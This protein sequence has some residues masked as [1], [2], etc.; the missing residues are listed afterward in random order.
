VSVRELEQQIS[1]HLARISISERFK[2][3]A[4]KYLHELHEKESA[5]R[6]DIIQAQ[7]KA[8]QQC[9]GHIDGLVNLKT[10]SG[11][12]DGSLLSDDEYAHRRGKL[13]KEKSALEELLNDAGHQ[14]EHQLK[15]SEQTFEFAC[16]AQK[17]FAKGDPKTKREILATIGSNLIL[18]DKTLMIEAKKPFFILGNTLSPEKPILQPIEPEKT[19]VAQGR[20]V[21]SI[22]MR[23][24]VRGDLDDVRAFGYKAERAAALIYAHFKKEFRVPVE[25]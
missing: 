11:N 25:R 17:R 14:V 5:S 8:Y 1:Q 20:K 2:E 19:Q 3:W 16:T 23:P 15:L 10:S 21:P 6:K 18:K 24:Y 9:L 13:L 7:Q 4:I 12:R 22:F